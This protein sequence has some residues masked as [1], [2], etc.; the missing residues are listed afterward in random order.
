MPIGTCALPVRL[1]FADISS[2]NR[3]STPFT[4]SN[5]P[6]IPPAAARHANK[7]GS[8][9]K[10][11]NDLGGSNWRPAVRTTVTANKAVPPRDTRTLT[12]ALLARDSPPLLRLELWRDALAA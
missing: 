9:S 12:R 4:D 3:S 5:T 1:G 8:H 7:R 11:L 2:R 10:G 6:E